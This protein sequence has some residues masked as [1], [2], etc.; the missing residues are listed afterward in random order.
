[1]VGIT[2]SL[3]VIQ[4]NGQVTRQQYKPQVDQSALDSWH[5]SHRWTNE[6]LPH[7]NLQ[8]VFYCLYVPKIMAINKG[9]T[10]DLSHNNPTTY[11]YTIAYDLIVTC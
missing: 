7:G 3:Q 1:M 8:F 5:G 2:L 10:L 6:R 4:P 11:Q 9:Q